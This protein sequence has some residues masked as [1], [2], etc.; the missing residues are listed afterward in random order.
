[1]IRTAA[2]AVLALAAAPAFASD[3]MD[4]GQ[5][6]V[7]AF[8]EACVP[9]RLSYAGTKANAEALGWTVAERSA[10]PELDAM[11]AIMDAGATEAAE[12]MQAT[13]DYGLY[14]KPVA[15]VTHFLVVSRASFVIGEPD[16]PL[17]PWVYIG[18]YLYN[19]DAAEP[20]DPAPVSALVGNPISHSL[21]ED[22][23]VAHVWGPPC[24]MPR[25]GD[26]YLTFIAEDSPHVA[27]TG[28]SGLVL[29]FETS[30]PDPG[31]VVPETYC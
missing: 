30:E 1:M 9:E 15:D 3:S 28:F 10:H 2:I 26:S 24:P 16:D 17:N 22:G 19:L 20:I 25:T 31:Q 29:K 4:Y 13:F 27:A 8:A 21:D 5:A 23:L 12:E 6:F 11:M 14:S 7:D 18:C